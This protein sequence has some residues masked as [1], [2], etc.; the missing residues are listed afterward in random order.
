MSDLKRKAPSTD[1]RKKKYRSVRRTVLRLISF[2]DWYIR[3]DGTPIWGKRHID[4]PGVWV[5]C[6]YRLVRQTPKN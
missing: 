4:G 3:K 1:K 2:T 5:S 6:V